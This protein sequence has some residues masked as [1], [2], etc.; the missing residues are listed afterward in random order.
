MNKHMLGILG[1]SLLA[2]AGLLQ[3]EPVFEWFGG[4]I[5]DF[6]TENAP[7]IV[8]GDLGK[9]EELEF[10]ANQT[11]A[12]PSPGQYFTIPFPAGTYNELTVACYIKPERGQQSE[13]IIGGK[14]DSGEEGFRLQKVWDNWGLDIADGN[15]SAKEFVENRGDRLT[16]NTWQH[17]AAT[18][19]DGEITLYKDGIP[20][21]KLVSPI[22]EIVFR[23]NSIRVG[24]GPGAN[25]KL[26]Y[27]FQGRLTGIYIGTTALNESEIHDLM[28]KGNP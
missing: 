25:P 20:V 18:F 14:W 12:A 9:L 26:Y 8:A 1:F 13:D 5:A 17:I 16:M 7:A 23:G 15:N 2:G 4:E 11:A 19:K 28:T 6:P 3:A 22:K 10:T 27:P 21:T 24:S